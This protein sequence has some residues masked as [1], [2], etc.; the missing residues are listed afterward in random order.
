MRNQVAESLR[1]VYYDLDGLVAFGWH[2]LSSLCRHDKQA[3]AFIPP[4]TA[5]RRLRSASIKIFSTYSCALLLRQADVLAQRLQSRIAT[6][7]SEFWKD[8]IYAHPN[9]T[10]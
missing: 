10:Q 8:Q 4:A 1:S 5:S 9:A 2:V 7:E 6:Q 3:K